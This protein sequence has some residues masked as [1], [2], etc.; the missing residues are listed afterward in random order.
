MRDRIGKADVE[1][2]L[3]KLNVAAMELGLKRRFTVEYGSS[4]SG[5]A[6]VIAEYDPRLSH[7]ARTKIGN[8]YASAFAY[9]DAMRHGLTSVLLDRNY[10]N[11]ERFPIRAVSRLAFDPDSRSARRTLSEAERAIRE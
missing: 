6:H 2:A 1:S 7:P 10:P 11:E 8:A 3:N 4:T 5:V 9:V